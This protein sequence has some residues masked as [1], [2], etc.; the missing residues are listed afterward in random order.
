[1]VLRG[2]KYWAQAGS[3]RPTEAEARGAQV[4]EWGH[5]EEGALG[6]PA[7]AGKRWPHFFQ[8]G[9]LRHKEVWELAQSLT[10]SQLLGKGQLTLGNKVT[11]TSVTFPLGSRDR[12]EQPEGPG[13]PGGKH[14]ALASPRGSNEEARGRSLHGT[15]QSQVQ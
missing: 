15:G 1:M 3:L 7:T 5:G 2:V 8:M 10:V 9:K 12:Q 4:P 14:L 6:G 13:L 11:Q